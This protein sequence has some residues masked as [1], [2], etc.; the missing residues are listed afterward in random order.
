MSA[1]IAVVVVLASAFGLLCLFVALEVLCDDFLVPALSA[2]ADRTKWQHEAISA[3][4]LALGA[5]AAEIVLGVTA[6]FESAPELSMGTMTGSAIIAFTMLPACCIWAS[7]G[8]EM[9]LEL[10]PLLRD[11]A[12]FIVAVVALMVVA[13]RNELTPLNCAALVGVFFIYAVILITCPLK[14]NQA[15]VEQAGDSEDQ[16]GSLQGSGQNNRDYGTNATLPGSKG[17]QKSSKKPSPAHNVPEFEIFEEWPFT[18]I[19]DPFKVLMSLVLNRK[20]LKR[21]GENW[22]W[23][24]FISL[25]VL[26]GLSECVVQLIIVLAERVGM[27]QHL[28]GITILAIGTQVEDVFGTM[29]L[30]KSGRSTSAMVT[31]L[32]SQIT[33]YALGVGAP[34]LAYGLIHGKSVR[35]DPTKIH[36]VLMSTLILAAVVGCFFLLCLRHILWAQSTQFV[37]Q[38]V[39]AI[40]LM[41][42]YVTATVAAVILLQ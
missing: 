22:A 28:A 7:R 38:N 41:C 10:L 35:L 9:P 14:S 36:D 34:F 8:R 42:A 4:V 33:N 12:F 31:A 6:T 26:V 29:A 11:S 17:A 3:G 40:L 37:L 5:S 1:F 18:L 21:T 30:A 24:V 19:S 15:L 23:G 2:L 27:S 13:S 25:V 32:G 16:M 20:R 39:D